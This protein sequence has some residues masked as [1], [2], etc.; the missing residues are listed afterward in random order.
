MSWQ[1][2]YCTNVHA[3]NT[4]EQTRAQLVEHAVAVQKKF[5][6][7]SQLGV[8]L[9]LSSSTASQMLEQQRVTEFADFLAESQ[10]IPYTLNGFPY[11]DFHREVVRHN[12]YLPTWRNAARTEYTLQLI[13]I[14][15]QLLPAGK[16]GSISTVPLGWGNPPWSEVQ[17]TAATEQISRVASYLQQLEDESG[18]LIYLCLEPEPGCELQRSGDLAEFFE[19]YLLLRDPERNRRYI[20]VCHDVC[21][22]SVM[23]ESQQEAL[24]RY[25][26]VG[27]LIGKVQISSAVVVPFA[28]MAPE[29]REVAFEELGQFAE[30][31]YLH[32][33]LVQQGTEQPEFHEDLSDALEQARTL[34][35]SQGGGALG[36]WLADQEWR[37]HFHVP[38][39]LEKFGR[40]KTSHAE[41]LTCL[42]ILRQ[43]PELKHLEVETYA[44]NVLPPALRHEQLADGIAAEMDW[45]QSA[46][47]TPQ[48]GD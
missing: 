25:L 16:E 32:Q 29:D 30:H 34:V 24:H 17:L 44:W 5:A 10:L 43:F 15:D 37:V 3:G 19:Q 48:N 38:V 33:T 46:L 26:N 39:Y 8:G 9:W 11:G 47:T 31:R 22:A 45:L 6:P 12:V 40:L 35:Q 14:L 4:L 27:A 21:H 41:I 2:G 23:F 7:E 36:T 1:I 20:R 18:R 13:R 42:D 28:E